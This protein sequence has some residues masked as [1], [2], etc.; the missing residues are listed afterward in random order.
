MA[1]R[2]ER[3]G[4]S[5]LLVCLL[6]GAEGWTATRAGARPARLRLATRMSAASS[7][8]DVDVA[9]VGGGPAGYAMAALMS[10]TH[11]HSV[12]I[13][14]PDPEALWP[15]NYGEWK[16]EWETLS[17]RLGMPSLVD[18]CVLREWPV[19]DCFFGGSYGTPWDDRTRLQRA[20]VQVNRQALKKQLR[21]KLLASGGA[22]VQASL[23]ARLAAPNLFEGGLAHDA[24]GSSLQLSNGDSVRAR[25]VVDATGFESKLVAREDHQLSGAWAAAAPGYQIAY[26]CSVEVQGGDLGPYDPNA[27][28]LFD[29]RTDHFDGDAAWQGRAEKTPTFVYAMPQGNQ[30]VFFEETSL[31]GR[32]EKRLSFGECKKRLERRLEHLGVKVVPGS[33]EEEEFCYIP[34]G[35]ALPDLKQRVVAF[36]GA[37][38]MVHPSTGYQACRMLASSTDVAAALSSELR[39]GS[40]PDAAAAAAYRAMWPPSL[41]LQRDFQ[42]YGGEFLMSQ[43]VERLRGFFSAFFAL[44]TVVWGGFLAGWPGLPGNEFHDSW[45][46]RLR[47]ALS[48]FW[49]MPNDVRFAM[50]SY[51]VTYSFEYGPGLLRSFATPLFGEGPEPYMPASA[52]GKIPNTYVDG[53]MAAKREALEMIRNQPSKGTLPSPQVAELELPS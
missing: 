34:M 38:A 46:K 44:E 13:V 11:G 18:D 35:G 16:D 23:R 26:G 20:Y 7:S 19:T 37:G 6:I 10:E 43:P 45:D 36:G 31:V 32:G 4:V 28:T 14:D 30:R 15:N 52:A 3:G 22:I 40:G 1:R 25:V 8:F 51:A 24:D 9:V 50:M 21:A 29:Y 2:G 41:R 17:R 33:I 12:V 49:L 27:M 53:D 5:L 47:F 39:A 48:L 42:V